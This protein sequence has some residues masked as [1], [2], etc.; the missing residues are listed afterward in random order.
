MDKP[1]P[2][3][4]LI[5]ANPIAGG[6]KG[7]SLAEKAQRYFGQRGADATLR[8]TGQRGDATLFARQAVTDGF[9]VVVVVGGDGTINEAGQGLLRSPAAMGI[10]PCGSGNGLARTLGIPTTV[11]AACDLILDGK[12]VAI[13]VGQA[14]ERYFFLVL[15]V[16]FD[17]RVG[18]LFD[19]SPVRGPL[20]YFYLSAKEFFTYRPDPVKLSFDSRCLDLKPF[21]VAVANGQQYGNN[22]QIAPEAKVNDGLFDICIVHRFRLVDAFSALPKLFSGK[23]QEHDQVDLYRSAQVTIE[24]QADDYVNLDG[25]AVWEKARIQVALVPRALQVLVPNNSPALMKG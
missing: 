12:P 21:V 8:F 15:G 13:D 1:D 9:Q 20:P 16:G 11:E 25:E 19:E 22:A 6:G 18:R 23:I 2:R 5:V 17:A 14:N 7:A 24:R 10:L 4:L 3:K